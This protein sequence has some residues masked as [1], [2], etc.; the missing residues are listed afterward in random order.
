MCAFLSSNLFAVARISE[1][2][3]SPG[4]R[5]SIQKNYKMKINLKYIISIIIIII[6]AVGIH[7]ADHVAPSIRQK[8]ALT[9]PTSG[10]RSVGIVRSRTQATELLLLVL[11]AFYWALAVFSFIFFILYTVVRTPWAG[12]QSV[13]RPLSAGQQKGRTN[14]GMR[15]SSGIMGFE[16]TTPV[17]E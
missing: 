5:F 4:N 14:T 9:S 10:C 15:T 7:H 1:I 8:L 16:P 11:Q 6:S 2:E 13:L 3:C 12:D 17:L